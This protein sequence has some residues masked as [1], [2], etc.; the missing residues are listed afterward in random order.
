M[1]C[2]CKMRCSTRSGTD[3]QNRRVQ[4]LFWCLAKFISNVYIKFGC[5]SGDLFLH[6]MAS[7]PRSHSTLHN[8]Y[9]V[10]EQCNTMQIC[11]S[12]LLPGR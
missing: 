9:T 2:H 12:N 6:K 7:K 10:G 8:C 3:W 11:P 1:L 5:E 4:V